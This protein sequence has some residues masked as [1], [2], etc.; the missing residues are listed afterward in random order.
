MV[1][2]EPCMPRAVEEHLREVPLQPG[3]EF[4]PQLFLRF[5]SRISVQQQN[6]LRAWASAEPTLALGCSPRSSMMLPSECPNESDPLMFNPCRQEEAQ[7]HTNR[8]CS[9]ISRCVHLARGGQKR[10]EKIFAPL[11]DTTSSLQ[12]PVSTPVAPAPSQMPLFSR[13][14]SPLVSS[15]F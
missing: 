10:G 2:V 14:I 7:L 4:L 11:P 9:G 15:I 12:T 1:D 8:R 13:T 5:I 6:D 3:A